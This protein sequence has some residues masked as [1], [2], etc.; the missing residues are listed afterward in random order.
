MADLPRQWTCRGVIPIQAKKQ[1][2][3]YIKEENMSI[4]FK[5]QKKASVE[6]F[7]IQTEYPKTKENQQQGCIE[8]AFPQNFIFHP[9]MY[10]LLLYFIQ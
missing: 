4:V 2:C 1:Y 10:S 9:Q 5:V 3:T 8:N 6:H 7:N